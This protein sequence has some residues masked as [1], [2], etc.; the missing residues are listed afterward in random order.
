MPKPRCVMTAILFHE[1]GPV[2]S[3]LM[4]IPGSHKIGMLE[5]V[6]P[7]EGS[8][9]YTVMEIDEKLVENLAERHGIETIMGKP[10]GVAF[11]HCN[12]VHGSSPNISPWPRAILY[13]NYNS[14]ENIPTGGNDRA[15]FHNNPNREALK[16]VAFSE[17][18]D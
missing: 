14:V 2:N 16:P 13:I 6:T 5:E 7:E 11:I 1:S 17:L 12:L 18:T 9:G 10:G 4:L 15:W 8:R 3:P